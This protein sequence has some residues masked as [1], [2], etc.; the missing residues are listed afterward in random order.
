MFDYT[1]VRLYKR[2]VYLLKLIAAKLGIS[3][4]ELVKEMAEARAKELKL[5]DNSR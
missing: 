3:I 1:N 5:D 4:I 2:T